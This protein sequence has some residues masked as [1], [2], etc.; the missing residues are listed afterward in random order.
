MGPSPGLRSRLAQVFVRL[1]GVSDVRLFG[2]VAAWVI[3]G[4]LLL[5][6]VVLPYVVPSVRAR[7][8]LI[9]RTDATRFHEIALAQ[10]SLI[11]TEGWSAW[12]AQPYDQAPAGVASAVYVLVYPAPWAMLPINAALFGI[13]V[14]A[15]RRTLA[16]M[17]GSRG[18]A[19]AA[20]SPF[21]VFPSF[22]PI[23]GQIHKDII[24]GAGVL[25]V[26]CALELARSGG[27]G[28]RWIRNLCAA[29]L[30]G[31]GLIWLGRFYLLAVT[32]VSAVAFAGVA[33]LV[34]QSRRWR[35]AGIGGLLIVASVVGLTER[36]RDTRVFHRARTEER[37]PAQRMVARPP[38]VQPEGSP[39]DPQPDSGAQ[40]PDRMLYRLCRERQEF[41]ARYSR[42]AS[43]FDID[44]PL[45][46]TEDFIRYFPRALAAG[47][48]VPTPAQWGSAR[49]QIGQLGSVLVPFEMAVAYAVLA[50]VAV[51]T[52]QGRTPNG[53]WPL[54]A[55]CAT[56]ILVHV[57]AVPNVGA[58]YRMRA[59]TFVTLVCALLGV[60]LTTAMTGR[61]VR[62]SR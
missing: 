11:R 60:V 30:G 27:G 39:C 28:V 5:Q 8:G 24:T 48:L 59:F 55:F 42:A 56:Y 40:G 1:E 43:T 47:V 36:S 53:L 17:L 13:A 46:T 44:R 35:M 29:M 14:V 32:L 34:P 15:T 45:R 10:A 19:L 26:L 23:W 6:L 31:V 57:Y 12:R 18:V 7:D 33:F 3:G 21:F 58:L 37:V 20:V 4:G 62:R 52:V 49:S 54:L 16:S 9:P 50:W 25:L 38:V 22:V 51:L 2:A 41:G 61:T